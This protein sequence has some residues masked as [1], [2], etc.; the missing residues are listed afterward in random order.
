MAAA[1]LSYTLNGC[2]GAPGTSADF[3]LTSP[4]FAGSEPGYTAGWP[5]AGSRCRL[6]GARMR[7]R[8]RAAVV[9]F[10]IQP[11]SHVLVSPMFTGC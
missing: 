8:W 2:G 11:Q 9:V 7:S 5:G 4:G 10:T 1:R 3:H 6:G